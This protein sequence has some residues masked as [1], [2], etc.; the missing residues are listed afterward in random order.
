MVVQKRMEFWEEK[1][2]EGVEAKDMLYRPS[3]IIMEKIKYETKTKRSTFET[4]LEKF[5][6]SA[7]LAVESV[8]EII[9]GRFP[10]AHEINRITSKSNSLNWSIFFLFGISEKAFN[11]RQKIFF[12]E[13]N[14]R[15]PSF[16]QK[17]A[18]KAIY[19]ECLKT[20]ANE[21]RSVRNGN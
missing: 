18:F 9:G 20:L 17:Q 5:A 7:S 2:A 16:K 15:I 13:I 14:I 4:E 12:D 1:F 8:K 19:E 6:K 21:E 11:N 10:W 3:E